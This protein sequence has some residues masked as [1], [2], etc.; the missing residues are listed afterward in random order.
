ME[1]VF[2]DMP[3]GSKVNANGQDKADGVPIDDQQPAVVTA[4]SVTTHSRKGLEVADER[5]YCCSS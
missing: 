4:Y 1:D 2:N 5:E 3:T